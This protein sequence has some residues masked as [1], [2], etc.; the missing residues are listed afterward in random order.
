M[1]K[2]ENP[3]PSNSINRSADTEH[4]N[5]N[6]VRRQRMELIRSRTERFQ[7]GAFE[8]FSV[9]MLEDHNQ[10]WLEECREYS[11]S[12]RETVLKAAKIDIDNIG[13][14]VMAMPRALGNSLDMSE[15]VACMFSAIDGVDVYFL[16]MLFALQTG[17]EKEIYEAILGEGRERMTLLNIERSNGM[18]ENPMLRYAQLAVLFDFLKAIKSMPRVITLNPP[19]N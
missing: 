7:Q 5:Q 6:R 1:S 13:D 2:R 15:L 4:E 18:E 8:E 19:R 11:P 3:G 9:E 16:K 12:L 14:R 17:N 10:S